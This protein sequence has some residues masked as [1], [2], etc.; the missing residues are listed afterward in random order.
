MGETLQDSEEVAGRCGTLTFEPALTCLDPRTQTFTV[1]LFKPYY[2]TVRQER[3]L[4]PQHLPM[5]PLVGSYEVHMQGVRSRA[6]F[7]VYRR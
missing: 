2:S 5:Q 4:F 3:A 7:Q 6:L 1:I